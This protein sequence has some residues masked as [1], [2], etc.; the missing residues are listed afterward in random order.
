MSTGRPQAQTGA[1]S[2][3]SHVR[4]VHGPGLTASVE[5]LIEP[6]GGWSAL[7]SPGESIAVKV[8]LLRGAAPEKAVCTHPETLRCVL[9]A[10]KQAGA[11]PFVA[12]S[13]GGLNGPA[14]VARAFKISGMTDVC[15]AEGV[16]IVD[17]EDD[18]AELRAPDGRL[19]RSFPVGKAFLDA[20]AVVQ[21]GVLKTHQLMR[22]TGGVKLTF[23]CIPGLA[24]AKLHVRAQKRDD[25]A[26]MLL[27]LHLAMRPRFTIIDGIVAM[28]GQGPGSGTARELGSLF[29]AHD[30]VALD[31]ALADRTAHDRRGVCTVAS[32]E[33]RGLVDLDAP[34]RLAG[35]PIEPDTGFQPARRDLQELLP[36]ALHRTARN[37]IT[38]RPRLVDPQACTRC[39]ECETI[40]GAQAITLSPLP[41]FDD[42]ACVRC[43]ACTEVCPTAAIDNVTPRV[44]RLFGARG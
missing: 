8:N 10:L 2:L 26:N 7:V 32:S 16:Q 12:D 33:R 27:D 29:A 40:C 31:V 39:G 43:Y 5:R 21:V 13:P 20:D 19:F 44:A 6:F 41:T 11:V 9:R 18:G 3:V 36:P 17:V 28:E 24:K 37:L 42:H 34:F 38:A 15:A 25:F 22:L 23:G 1:P 4:A 35:D 14:K 30:A